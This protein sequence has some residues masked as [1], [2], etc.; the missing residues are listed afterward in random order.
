MGYSTNV[1]TIRMNRDDASKSSSRRFIT[2]DQL[3]TASNVIEIDNV[4]YTIAS[5]LIFNTTIEVFN[6]DWIKVNPMDY[7]TLEAAYTDGVIYDREKAENAVVERVE[8]TKPENVVIDQNIVEDDTTK[9][10][11][12]DQEDVPSENVEEVPP[13]VDE[14]VHTTNDDNNVDDIV[15]EED[16]DIEKEVDKKDTT[17]KKQMH[18]KFKRKN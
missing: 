15:K 12:I 11:P 17:P 9:F 6:T 7:T 13:I 4:S 1:R 10:I 5:R 16:Q 18:A 3:A 8:L 2:R 14:E